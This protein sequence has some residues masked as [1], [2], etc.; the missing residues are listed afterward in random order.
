MPPPL[1][2]PESQS[3]VNVHIIDSTARLRDLPSKDFFE[4]EFV[5]FDTLDIPSYSFL[6]EHPPS[7]RRVLFDLGLRQDWHNLAPEVVGYIKKEGWSITV[8]KDV[9]EILSEGGVKLDTIEAV[10]WRQSSCTLLI[11]SSS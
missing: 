8:E 2:I 6:I 11:F 3:A 10:I 9:A 7:S 4:P 5:G 1:N